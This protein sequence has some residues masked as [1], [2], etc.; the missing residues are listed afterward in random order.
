MTFFD[1][2]S[3]VLIGTS[4]FL[5]FN[6]NF[7]AILSEKVSEESKELNLTIAPNQLKQIQDILIK[8]TDGKGS[9][10]LITLNKQKANDEIIS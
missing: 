6:F 10:E 1:L 7:S 4:T 9:V 8:E 2:A 5:T 3:A